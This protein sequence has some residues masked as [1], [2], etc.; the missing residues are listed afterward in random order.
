MLTI[1]HR[2]KYF[3]EKHGPDIMTQG[4]LSMEAGI[5]LGTLA[6]YETNKRKAKTPALKKIAHV[7]EI[8][9]KCLDP[10]ITPEFNEL[11]AK[12]KP[13]TPVPAECPL[14][15]DL[16]PIYRH[17]TEKFKSLDL[18][19]QLRVLPRMEKIIDN[20]SS[21]I[22]LQDDAQKKSAAAVCVD[23]EG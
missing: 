16:N 17:L 6:N 15:K 10:E 19:G 2:I 5:P 9:W 21:E 8:D 18:S 11:N 14:R 7:F 12:K 3:R 1:G 20:P 4:N 13:S 22:I 23:D